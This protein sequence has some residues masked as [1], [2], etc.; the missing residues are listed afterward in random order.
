[1]N[2]RHQLMEIALTNML[3]R[4]RAQSRRGGEA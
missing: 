3:A 1:M 4:H 2:G